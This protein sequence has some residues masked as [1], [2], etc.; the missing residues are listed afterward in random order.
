MARQMVS[1]QVHQAPPYGSGYWGLGVSVGGDG[2]SLTFSHG[3]R[4]EGFVAN[5][6]MW[7]NRGRGIVIMMNG[8]TGPLM[9]EIMRGFTTEFIDAPRRGAPK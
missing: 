1:K 5:M 2:D 6:V 3:G 9:A 4:D 7:P 8:V